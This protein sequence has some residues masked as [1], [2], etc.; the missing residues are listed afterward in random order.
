MKLLKAELPVV[1]EPNGSDFELVISRIDLFVNKWKSEFSKLLWNS[2]M[3]ILCST[4][5]I[6]FNLFETGNPIRPTTRIEF[7]ALI[8]EKLLGVMYKVSYKL[9]SG[10]GI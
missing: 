3:H 10:S 7:V 2:E 8:S 6:H 1:S 9:F 4:F 5:K